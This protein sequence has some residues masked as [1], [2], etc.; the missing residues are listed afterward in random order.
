MSLL[1]FSAA[2][3]MRIAAAESWIT[4]CKRWSV[5]Q[6]LMSIFLFIAAIGV[7]WRSR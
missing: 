2:I 4:G 6:L 1:L 7:Y 3:Y 5:G